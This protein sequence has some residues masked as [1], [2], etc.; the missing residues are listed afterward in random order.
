MIASFAINVFISLVI[1]VRNLGDVLA[2]WRYL[3]YGGIKV[4]SKSCPCTDTTQQ[5]TQLTRGQIRLVVHHIHT[6]LPK[7]WM[8]YQCDGTSMHN[9]VRG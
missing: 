7:F 3:F 6:V 9:N 8:N 5:L 2:R 4:E 1:C